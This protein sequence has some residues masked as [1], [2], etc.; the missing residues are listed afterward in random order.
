MQQQGLSQGRVV[1]T[2]VVALLERCMQGR[3]GLLLSCGLGLSTSLVVGGLG[4]RWPVLLPALL[5]PLASLGVWRWAQRRLRQP[6][7]SP[8]T[9]C[10][11]DASVLRDRLWLDA[12]LGPEAS[13]RRQRIAQR[14]E[15]V[16]SLAAACAELDAGCEVALLVLLERLVHR[17]LAMD[18]HFCHLNRAPTPGS[19]LLLDRRLDA[20]HEHLQNRQAALTRSYEAALEEALR[21]PEVPATVVL[22]TLLLES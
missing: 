2:N 21:C 20:L 16:R 1:S 8:P 10:L 22:S 7:P 4:W 15:A 3:E 9:A 12:E 5:P 11:L 13:Q 14:L 17:A 18:V 6:A 19:L